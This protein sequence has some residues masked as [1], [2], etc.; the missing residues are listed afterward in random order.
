MKRWFILLAISLCCCPG[1]ATIV[2]DNKTFT[3]IETL[4]DGAQCTIEG[5]NYNNKITTP[6]NV[7]IPAKAA[8]VVITCEAEGYN[9]ATE[10]IDTKMDGWTFGNILFGGIVGAI[11]DAGTKSGFKYPEKVVLELN[12][13]N[14]NSIEERDT[15]YDKREKDFN[16][17]IDREVEAALAGCHDDDKSLCE[18]KVKKINKFREEQ[19]L[20]IKRDKEASIITPPKPE[21]GKIITPRKRGKKA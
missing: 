15:Y 2:S 17:K 18:R 6:A 7:Q 19:L 9:K 11:I 3:Q 21:S 13:R 8:P 10:R 12:K 16:A 5:D 1:C 4:P 20:V 14:F